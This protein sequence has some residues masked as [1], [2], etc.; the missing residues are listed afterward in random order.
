MVYDYQARVLG[1]NPYKGFRLSDNFF[2]I[3]NSKNWANLKEVVSEKISPL[4]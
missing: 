4:E 2:E 3:L 1:K